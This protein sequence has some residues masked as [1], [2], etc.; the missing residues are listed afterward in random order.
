MPAVA[1]SLGDDAD[2]EWSTG[3][4]L[5]RRAWAHAKLGDVHGFADV[6]GGTGDVPRGVTG[7]ALM[8]ATVPANVRA[9]GLRQPDS[10]ALTGYQ[11]TGQLLT[12]STYATGADRLPG[13]PRQG[14]CSP[15]AS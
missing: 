5:G 10:P 7:A 4:L 9:L 12:R 3:R 11:E 8:V 14:R 2:S 15:W 1:P 13:S 6:V